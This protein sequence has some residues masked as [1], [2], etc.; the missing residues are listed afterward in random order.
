MVHKRLV[1][2]TLVQPKGR[3]AHVKTNYNQTLC[4]FPWSYLPQSDVV[5][6]T[7]DDVTYPACLKKM[8][9]GGK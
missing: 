9:N 6:I 8:G 7:D 2:Q 3:K 5:T 1:T 4:L